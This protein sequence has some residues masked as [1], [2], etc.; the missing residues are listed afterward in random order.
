MNRK[1]FTIMIIV[2]SIVAILSI[3]QNAYACYSDEDADC[4]M[5]PFDCIPYER[6]WAMCGNSVYDTCYCTQGNEWKYCE[7]VE[8]I[9]FCMFFWNCTVSC[10]SCVFSE[11]DSFHINLCDKSN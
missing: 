3:E 6:D 8:D 1:S 2:L 9:H 7:E 10:S 11:E 5:T 4:E